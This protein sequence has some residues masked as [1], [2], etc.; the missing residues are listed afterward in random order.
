M[1]IVLTGMKHCGKTTL[2]KQLSAYW[3]CPFADTDELLEKYYYR[4]YGEKLNCREIFRKHGEQFFRELEATVIEELL[5]VRLGKSRVLALGG[6][7]PL[8]PQLHDSLKELGRI[9]Y[10]K[11]EPEEIFRRIEKNGLPPYIDPNRPFESFLEVFRKREAIYEEIAD[12][13]L[14]PFGLELAEIAAKIEKDKD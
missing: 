13:V 11:V 14:E 6:G 4:C 3:S 7:L 2:G 9:I 1:K 12:Q 10:L 8:Q 5:A